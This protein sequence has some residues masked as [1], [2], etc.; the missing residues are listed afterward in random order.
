MGGEGCFAMQ[1]VKNEHSVSF[2]L[3][4]Q[5]LNLSGTWC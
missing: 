1:K 5:N 3:D 2:L 4:L